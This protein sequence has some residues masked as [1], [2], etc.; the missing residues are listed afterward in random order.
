MSLLAGGAGTASACD[1]D[2]GD[3]CPSLSCSACL[4]TQAAL[5]WSPRLA[6]GKVVQSEGS[7][8][9]LVLEP[10]ACTYWLCDLDH[11]AQPH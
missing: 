1:R 5:H 9:R 7:G 6:T 2:L 10:G 4:G 8:V 3:A 11:V